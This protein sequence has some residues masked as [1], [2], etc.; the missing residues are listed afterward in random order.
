[1]AH[2]FRRSLARVTVICALFAL[3]VA[4]GGC[5]AA[6][7]YVGG[8]VV[9]HLADHFAKSAAAKRHVSQAYCLYSVDRAFHDLTHHHVIFGAL[10]VHQALKNCEAGF[11]KSAR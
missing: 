7:H 8:V 5:G 4:A 2:S 10:N 6:S 1:M 11:S 3:P 9:R